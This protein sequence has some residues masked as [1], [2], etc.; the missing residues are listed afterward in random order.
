MP[1]EQVGIFSFFFQIKLFAILLSF[2][3]TDKLVKF[4][5]LP[6][7]LHISSQISLKMCSACIHVFL[8]S[9]P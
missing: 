8:G 9:M 5:S 2:Y 3:I 6:E 4:V 1:S 7:D